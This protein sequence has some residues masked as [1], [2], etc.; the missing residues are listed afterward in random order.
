MPNRMIVGRNREFDLPLE[1]EGLEGWQMALFFI[2]GGGAVYVA[3]LAA[4]PWGGW[5]QPGID[6]G[7]GMMLF[8]LLVL[9]GSIVGIVVGAKLVG[10]LRGA[11]VRRLRR[12]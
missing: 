12:T 2:V 3:L 4:I 5:S 1:K 10:F 6:P 9:A 8:A 7:L 11:R